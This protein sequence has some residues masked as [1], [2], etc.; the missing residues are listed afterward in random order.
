MA[1]RPGELAHDQ[2]PI[3]DGLPV[4]ATR[5]YVH[6]STVSQNEDDADIQV[7]GSNLVGGQRVSNLFGDMQ[8]SGRAYTTGVTNPVLADN[9]ALDLLVV[10]PLSVVVAM[11]L[12]IQAVGDMQIQVYEH[13]TPVG[14][15]T[16]NLVT[17][18]NRMFA[19]TR[20]PKSSAFSAPNFTTGDPGTIIFDTYIA[21]GA[22]NNLISPVSADL[23]DAVMLS[24]VKYLMRL[25]NRSGQ[26][27]LANITATGVER[28]FSV[29]NDEQIAAAVAA[30]AV[31]GL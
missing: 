8:A 6:D 11:S 18:L 28:P 10:I 25:T 12:D 24:G 23:G 21:G 16:P 2:P 20:P 17:N 27:A 14:D 9:A 3:I 15:G 19:A 5:I 26:A 29:L 1:H 31:Y 22:K 7:A 13:S 30:R 4:R